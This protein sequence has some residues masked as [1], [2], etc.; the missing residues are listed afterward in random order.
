MEYKAAIPTVSGLAVMVHPGAEAWSPDGAFVRKVERLAPPGTRV[1]LHPRSAVRDV[2]EGEGVSAPFPDKPYAF[3]GWN[4]R[5][6]PIHIFVDGTETPDSVKWLMLHEVGHSVVNATPELRRKLRRTPIPPT[7]AFSDETHGNVPEERWCNAF[8]DAHAPVPGLDRTW[9]RRRTQA[10][11]YG[12][13]PS[14]AAA[15]AFWEGEEGALLRVL[16]T[17]AERATIVG[18]GLYLAGER[19]NLV[20]Y[21][22]AGAAAI[23]VAVLAYAKHTQE[24]S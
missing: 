21:A 5:S 13:L 15:L 12:T 11:E 4:Q 19:K 7:Y 1:H 14:E 8:A 23:E 10:R 6:G 16:L 22:L 9:W 2:Y 3:R 24:K 17:T 20:K 18:L